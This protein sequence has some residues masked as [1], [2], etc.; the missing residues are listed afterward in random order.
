[1]PENVI[2]ALARALCEADGKMPYGIAAN[3]RMNFEEYT[4]LARVAT[5]CFLDV[6]NEESDLRAVRAKLALE[7]DDV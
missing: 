3:G 4:K 2:E 5:K 6:C 7:L 1:M